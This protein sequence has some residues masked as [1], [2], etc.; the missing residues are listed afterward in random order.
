MGK[1][2]TDILVEKAINALISSIEIYNKPDFKY[3]DENFSILLINAWELLLKAKIIKDNKNKR[4]SLYI[5]KYLIK[6]D[7]E[8]SKQW[9]YKTTR[10][11]NYMTISI[12]KC[13]QK[14]SEVIEE[15]V[16]SNIIT[17]LEIRDN[18]THFYT[19]SLDLVRN[20]HEIGSAS[21]ENFITLLNS[22]FNKDLSNYNL[23]LL[24]LA[25]FGQNPINAIANYKEEKYLLDYIEQEKRKYPYKNSSST[26]YALYINI[27]LSKTSKGASGVYLTNDPK[28]PSV[29]LNS[30]QLNAR[31]P[32]DYDTL[33]KKCH[34]RYSDFKLN[35]TFH[36]FRRH[37]FTDLKYCYPL[38][39]TLNETG[40]PKYY[41]SS[42]ILEKLD[43]VYTR[44]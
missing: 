34:T 6:R 28:A 16:T 23:Y 40:N 25:F 7:G 1:K 31:Y 26:N 12:T 33:V 11:G 41:Y 39:P 36:D 15:A 38:Y 43:E 10:T 32:F 18:S 30:S 20:I 42:A 37:Y 29:Q 21:I 44:I 19:P 24:P 8:R 17:L 4:E 27:G 13:L 22:W 9:R 35:Q 3:R 5:K 2:I 14:L